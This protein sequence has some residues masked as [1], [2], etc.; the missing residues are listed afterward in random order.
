MLNNK[1]NTWGNIDITYSSYNPEQVKFEP[2]IIHN[3]DPQQHKALM[4]M[5][6]GKNVFLHGGA[7]SGKTS[8][9]NAFM[10]QNPTRRMLFLSSDG[11]NV[12][13]TN[14]YDFFSRAK[15][16][17]PIAPQT[18]PNYTKCL[19]K[20]TI[21]EILCQIDCIVFDNISKVSAYF[22]DAINAYINQ[23]SDIGREMNSIQVVVAGNFYADSPGQAN[24]PVTSFHGLDYLDSYAFC[25]TTWHSIYFNTI[26]LTNNYWQTADVLFRY[27]LDNLITPGGDVSKAIEA[28]NNHELKCRNESRPKDSFALDIFTQYPLL[29][30]KAIYARDIQGMFLDSVNIISGNEPFSVE[31]LYSILS[32]VRSLD[33]VRLDQFIDFAKVSTDSN[34]RAFYENKIDWNRVFSPPGDT[35]SAKPDQVS[36]SY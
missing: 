14:L 32:R 6:Q 31:T 16:M 30:C 27:I 21:V 9:L 20:E 29:P 34:A 12:N 26:E 11:I 13:A 28:L 4:M 7:H 35:D 3:L 33:G 1:Q 10:H 5:N 19:N 15:Y 24:V 8:V 22:F 18:M 25:S 2:E 17:G 36:P 23:S